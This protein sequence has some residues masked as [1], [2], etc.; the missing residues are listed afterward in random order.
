MEQRFKRAIS[1][2]LA[3]ACA[4]VSLACF[5]LPLYV[6]RPFRHQGASELNLALF[7]LRVAPWLSAVSAV[8]CLVLLLW[9]W[10]RARGWVA[11]SALAI[12]LLLAI[13]GAWLSRV[14]IYEK[15]FHH[16]DSP[17]FEAE[18][19]AHLDRD[20]MVLAIRVNGTAR[21]Y[22][23]REMAYH[24]VVNDTVRGEPVVATY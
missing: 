13:S 20:D 3:G 14:N 8:V 4:L 12:C 23:I 15:M 10:P 1:I 11:R 5:A 22:P 19:R 2:M 6:I 21:A 24:H 17:T 16:L 18:D 7:V 9:N